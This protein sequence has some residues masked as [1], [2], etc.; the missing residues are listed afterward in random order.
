M[1]VLDKLDHLKN[2]L[3]YYQPEM[4]II[5]YCLAFQN[6]VLV[7]YFYCVIASLI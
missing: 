2:H 4:I 5:L 7:L 1:L 3:K 6:S